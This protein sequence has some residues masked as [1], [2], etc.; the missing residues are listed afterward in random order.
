MGSRCDECMTRVPYAT[1]IATIMCLIGVVIFCWTMY[2]GATL[3]AVMLDGV[4][5]VRLEWLEAVQMSV[6]GIGATMGALGLMV[7]VVGCLATGATRHK[8]YKAWNARIGGRI[9]CAVFMGIAYVLQITWLIFFVFLIAITIFVT[10]FWELCSSN[11]VKETKQINFQQFD[12]LFPG[13]N[14]D[15]L[16]INTDDRIKLFCK[17]FVEKA[18]M[19]FILATFA[20]MLVILSLVHYLMCLSAN[21]AHIRDHEKLQELQELQSLNDLEG[22]T[23]SKDRF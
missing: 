2:R 4:F 9:S 14:R 23:S 22:L 17:D 5:F 3:S 8:V 13:I 11:G 1:L 20:C 10:L 6:V 19:M 15:Y 7:L 18:E 21:Y 12:F 16:N